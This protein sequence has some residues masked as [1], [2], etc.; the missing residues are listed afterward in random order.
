MRLNIED[1]AKIK[2]ADII[3]DGITVIAGE[4]NTGKSTVGKILFSMFNSLQN[5]EDKILDDRAVA[6]RNSCIAPF[7]KHVRINSSDFSDYVW[8][9]GTDFYRSVFAELKEISEKNNMITQEVVADTVQK[10]M[11]LLRINLDNVTDV[12]TAIQN[13]CENIMTVWNVPEETIIRERISRYFNKVFSTQINMLSDKEYKESVLTLKI[14]EKHQKVIFQNNDCVK[15]EQ[16][17]EINHKAIYIDNPLIIDYLGS[18]KGLNPMEEM[19]TDLLNEDKDDIFSGVVEKI[20]TEEKLTNI[21][22]MLQTVVDGEIVVDQ[23]KKFCLK[24]GKFKEPIILQNLSTGLKSFVILKMLLENG[25]LKEKDVVILDEPEIHLH[26]QWQIVYA[27]LIVLLQKTFDLSI[28]VTTHS[29]YFVDA[30]NLFSRK[31]ETDD[32]VNY[33]LSSNIDNM[34]QMEHVSDHIDSI[35]R[36][37]VSPIQVLDTLRK[38]KLE[39]K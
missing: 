24:S 28:I 38:E 17:T 39:D 34:V 30:L 1:F 11:K 16:E 2:E 36:K 12:E 8:I 3:I 6:V 4:N 5:I 31:Y 13:I 25:S 10:V 33:Y 37:M 15:Y 7:F 9:T 18:K 23:N 14:K 19:L 29:P 32:K 35:Y 22:K 20:L 26:P 21:Y 27:E